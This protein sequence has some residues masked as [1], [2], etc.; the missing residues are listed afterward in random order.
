MTAQCYGGG[1]LGYTAPPPTW[2]PLLPNEALDAGATTAV[3]DS[4]DTIVVGS[5]GGSGVT[6]Y[7]ADG[8][9]PA[10]VLQADKE[11]GA[12]GASVAIT[13][14]GDLVAAGTQASGAVLFLRKSDADNEWEKLAVLTARAAP[15]AFEGAS[16]AFSGDG[17]RLAVGA[18]GLGQVF[19]WRR[20][21]AKSLAFTFEAELTPD[22]FSLSPLTQFGNAL[23]FDGEGLTLVVGGTFTGEPGSGNG[24]VWVYRRVSGTHWTVQT[25][26][27]APD[28]CSGSF[29]ASV[30]LNPA[31]NTFVV[32]SPGVQGP[33]DDHWKFSQPGAAYLFQLSD[34]QWSE[35]TQLS[36]PNMWT[37][38]AFG[39]AVAL[40]GGVAAVT[41]PSQHQGKTCVFER[42]ASGVWAYVEA[43]DSGIPR[44][45]TRAAFFGASVALSLNASTLVVGAPGAQSGAGGF[46]AFNDAQCQVPF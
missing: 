28:S 33:P 10:F 27:G 46:F 34:G 1:A 41:A 24:G 38:S 2:T 18:P 30:A 42:V 32:G 31:G 11:T 21:S 7:V 8:S 44:N 37:G 20:E 4:G 19:V 36:C 16:V 6:V 12:F 14:A 3:S 22:G 13:P 45:G 15:D 43:L 25:F 17:L 29:G 35:T 40:R 9:A 39:A 23:S 5:M 26:L